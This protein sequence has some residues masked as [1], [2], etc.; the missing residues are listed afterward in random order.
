MNITLSLASP[1]T[2][3]AMLLAATLVAPGTYAQEKKLAATPR[4]LS[5]ENKPWQGDFDAMLE[6]RMIRVLIPYSRTLYFSDKGHER[7]ITAE[8]VRD[9]ERYLNKKYAK[10]LGKRPLTILIIPTTRD[11][12]IPEINEG[13]GDIAA[14]NLTVTEARLT[15]VDFAAPKDRKPVQEFLVTGPSAPEV[16][17]LDDLS[18]KTIH[19]RPASSYAESLVALN[20]RFTAAGKAPVTIAALPEALEDEDTLEMLNAGLLALVVVDDWK[21]RLWAQVL[22]K[23]TVRDDLVLRSAGVIGWAIRK[24]SPQLD[25]A[26]LDFYMNS[27][28]K[29]GVIDYRLAQFHKRVKQIGNSTDNEG[30]TRFEATL[31]LFKRYGEHYGFDPLMLAA[32][33][34][35]ESQLRQEARSHVGAIGVMQI[36]PATGNQLR[37][38][39]IRLIEPNIHAGAKYMDQLMTR[40]FPDAQFTETNRTL[41]AF[42]AYNAGPGN[43]SKIRKE[44][45]QRGLDPDR[46]FNNVEI[47]TA[48]RIGIETTTYVRNIYK[49]YVAYKLRQEAQATQ[50]KARAQ[51]AP[52]AP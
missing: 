5:L 24:D 6:R 47:V 41:F 11:K 45:A 16:Q 19:V 14:G 1:A 46:W 34:Y 18:G 13:L 7:G 2:L 37:V 26:I 40:Y 35:Q 52:S 21:G 22:P 3:A 4:Q 39:N 10:Q 50:R 43:M 12:L 33:G 25:A 31:D 29:Q 27:L 28:K 23:I 17:T 38:G 48:E 51:V 49:Y 44:A 9:F 42:A 32:Q 15:H 30:L 20:E 8:N 36:M